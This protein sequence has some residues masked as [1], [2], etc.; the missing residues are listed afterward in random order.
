MRGH[1]IST[2]QIINQKYSFG[3]LFSKPFSYTKT[4]GIFLRKKSGLCRL[5]RLVQ[6]LGR[7]PGPHLPL[8]C[9]KKRE[10]SLT[11]LQASQHVHQQVTWMTL[12]FLNWKPPAIATV[13]VPHARTIANRHSVIPLIVGFPNKHHVLFREKAKRT[14]EG[15]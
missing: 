14:P 6:P 9:V 3:C 1:K 11:P 12:I 8:D 10:T 4:S 13:Q 5:I 15:C 2:Y 7:S